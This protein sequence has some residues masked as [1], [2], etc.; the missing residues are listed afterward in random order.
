MKVSGMHH[1]YNETL[2]MSQIGAHSLAE[3]IDYIRDYC[4][5]VVWSEIQTTENVLGKYTK[6]IDTYFNINVYYDPT[7]D[8]FYFEEF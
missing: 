1:L 6:Y 7:A 8:T 4:G 5:G 2:T 3:A